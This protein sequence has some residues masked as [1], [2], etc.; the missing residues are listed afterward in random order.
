MENREHHPQPPD[1]LDDQRVILNA[2]HSQQHEAMERTGIAAKV[3]AKL[4]AQPGKNIGKLF[5]SVTTI[6]TLDQNDFITRYA[7]GVKKSGIDSNG[8]KYSEETYIPVAEAYGGTLSPGGEFTNEDALIVISMIESL[9][10]A[11]GNGLIP[12]LN[13]ECTTIV[14]SKKF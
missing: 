3:K 8:E 7:I 5:P 12:N 10:E 9:K 14:E 4:G 6:P 13:P 11:R 1:T 2:I